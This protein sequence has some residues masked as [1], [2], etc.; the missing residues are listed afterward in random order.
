MLSELERYKRALEWIA[1][2][3]A[4]DCE[5][6]EMAQRALIPPPPE[7]EEVE[8]VH[9]AIYER[10]LFVCTV[11]DPKHIGANQM[12][13]KLIGSYQQE[14]PQPVERSVKVK[15]AIAKDGRIQVDIFDALRS[16]E[17]HDKGCLGKTGT[18]TFTWTD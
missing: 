5:Y 8:V 10:G 12:A 11:D 2:V 15:A 7:M 1:R 14:K 3:N 9:W 6:R 17:I 13:V 18:L 4:M 16:S